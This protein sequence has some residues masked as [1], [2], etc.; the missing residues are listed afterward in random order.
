MARKIEVFIS[1]AHKDEELAQTL[2]RALIF[3][4]GLESDEIRCTSFA[5]T[6]LSPGTDIAE[7]LR[8]DLKRCNYFMPLITKNVAS[9]EFVLFEIGA[10]WVLDKEVLPLVH[11][12]RPGQRVPSVISGLL[13]TDLSRIADVVKFLTKITTETFE[14]PDQIKAPQI[15]AAA[16]SFLREVRSI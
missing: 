2:V 15:I 1:H 8:K 14:A 12:M 7:G 3:G 13:H 6:G 10:A 9:S 5:P 16:R 11:R 4:S